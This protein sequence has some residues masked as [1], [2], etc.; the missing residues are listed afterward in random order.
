MDKDLNESFESGGGS[1]QLEDYVVRTEGIGKADQDLGGSQ[2]GNFLGEGNP[3]ETQDARSSTAEEALIKSPKWNE[4]EG[5]RAVPAGL[6]VTH[7]SVSD[8][9][10]A[11][12]GSGTSPTSSPVRMAVGGSPPRNTPSPTGSRNRGPI[13]RQNST[14]GQKFLQL[15]VQQRSAQERVLVQPQATV[16]PSVSAS[17]YKG[18]SS[19]PSHASTTHTSASGGEDKDGE[20]SSF[21]PG[22]QSQSSS[23]N[24]NGEYQDKDFLPRP[25]TNGQDA[26]HLDLGQIGNLPGVA[27]G[28]SISPLGSTP[29][30][31]VGA[32]E[33]DKHIRTHSPPPALPTAIPAPAQQSPTHGPQI[34]ED[35]VENV[36]T[37]TLDPTRPESP[38]VVHAPPPPGPSQLMPPKKNLAFRRLEDPELVHTRD[39]LRDTQR[40]MKDSQQVARELLADLER[41][42]VE[43][44]QLQYQV[45]EGQRRE[46]EARDQLIAAE[47]QGRKYHQAHQAAL[48]KLQQAARKA[49]VAGTSQESDSGATTALRDQLRTTTE[50]A[51]LHQAR[52]EA[53]QAELEKRAGQLDRAN[54]L[55]V[56][57]LET[58]EGGSAGLIQTMAQVAPNTPRAMGV[59]EV[60]ERSEYMVKGLWDELQQEKKG[61]QADRA[62]WE[63][64][65]VRLQSQTST[66]QR[67]T[68][69]EVTQA[70]SVPPVPPSHPPSTSTTQSIVPSELERRYRAVFTPL[71]TDRSYRTQ[72]PPANPLPGPGS[73]PDFPQTSSIP[74]SAPTHPVRT[75]VQAPSHPGPT[76]AQSSYHPSYNV[77]SGAMGGPRDIRTQVQSHVPWNSHSSGHPPSSKPKS[78]KGVTPL[79]LGNSKLTPNQLDIWLGNFEFVMQDECPELTPEERARALVHNTEES[80][81]KERLRELIVTAHP[82]LE[83]VVAW[84]KSEVLRPP[85]RFRAE[86]EA[87]N[88]RWQQ[89]QETVTEFRD[90]L[91]RLMKEASET[92]TLSGS[93]LTRVSDRFFQ[94]LPQACRLFLIDKS[95]PREL[96]AQ[97]LAVCDWVD[98]QEYMQYSEASIRATSA[99]YRTQEKP[100]ETPRAAPP[101]VHKRE[102]TRRH[103]LHSSSYSP[104]PRDWGTICQTGREGGAEILSFSI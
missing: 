54:Q 34:L 47:E 58:V 2:V 28:G 76:Q 57:T 3:R 4:P 27:R 26:N 46:D 19:D 85:D 43:V 40:L 63:T 68:R 12:Q 78:F 102:R 48:L 60:F 89:G 1:E 59:A 35:P 80:F 70:P 17:T 20:A 90:R 51:G 101:R 8:N 97:H 99:Q 42:Q 74:S 79:D 24:G 31:A 95:I 21:S 91:L 38:I 53:L 30:V 103:S 56:G 66:T 83:Q 10:L 39:Q 100:R 52:A 44:Q 15:D 61:R 67:S 45:G 72:M 18:S 5:P 86:R 55:M 32:V 16:H 93:D 87:A 84:I 96:T 23:G 65:R 81:H 77:D 75:V 33:T 13:T 88:I 9:G 6:S 71:P 92:S 82:T 69:T 29:V 25:G 37:Q 73:S 98:K 49:E 14:K 104:S 62:L 11:L 94:G 22:K 36:D 7:D 64:E 50:A 41:R